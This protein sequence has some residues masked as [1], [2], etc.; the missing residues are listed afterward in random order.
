MSKTLLYSS[1]GGSM[2]VMV[3]IPS[4][5]LQH[6]QSGNCILSFQSAQNT[7]LEWSEGRRYHEDKKKKF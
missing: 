2:L 1:Y 7:V 6:D 5:V 3:F 4:A